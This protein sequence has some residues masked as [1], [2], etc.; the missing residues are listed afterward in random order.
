VQDI[1][2]WDFDT[3]EPHNVPNQAFGLNDVG[4]PKVEALQAMIEVQTG[5]TIS[6]H[7]QR[8]DGSESFG[9]VVFLLVDS[10][11]TR[12]AIWE[13][14]LKLNPSVSL[15]VE[16]RMGADQGR[17][18]AINPNDM[19]D[20]EAWESSLY[21]SAEAQASACGTNPSVGPT[22]MMVA[23]MAVWQFMKWFGYETGR[24][25][26]KPESELMFATN[27]FMVEPSAW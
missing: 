15:V 18:Y 6:A 19:T 5:T 27:P 2:T 24:W 13:A 10:M 4:K 1:H 11:D 7:N 26:A 12:K 17:I 8:V 21:S 22:A 25:E 16:T 14:G 3:V 23:S 20:I 9:N